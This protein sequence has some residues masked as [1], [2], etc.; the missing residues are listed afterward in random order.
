SARS[1]MPHRRARM[2]ARAG[3]CL[4]PQPAIGEVMSEARGAVIEIVE[5]RKG[6]IGDSSGESMIVPDDVRINAQSLLCPAD[7]P[8]IVHGI[9]INGGELVRVTLT[10]FARRVEIKAEAGEG[11][12]TG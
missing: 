7:H 8:V 5:R 2:R 11:G 10:L 1:A 6:P 12:I 3:R 9:T 4:S